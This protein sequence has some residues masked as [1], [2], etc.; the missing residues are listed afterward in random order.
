ME[1]GKLYAIV[2]ALV[3]VLIGAYAMY[4]KKWLNKVLPQSMQKQGF[5]GAYGRT[6]AMQG[7]LAYAPGASWPHFNRCAYV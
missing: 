7:C 1:T 2:I 6:P 4:Q 3:L 5:V